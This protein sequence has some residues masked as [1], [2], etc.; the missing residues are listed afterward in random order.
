VTEAGVLGRF[1][2]TFCPSE[3]PDRLCLDT[4][5]PSR[6][7][8]LSSS[9]PSGDVTVKDQVACRYPLTKGKPG[10]KLPIGKLASRSPCFN[11]SAAERKAA[12]NQEYIL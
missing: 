9:L 4:P 1:R 8:E 3:A 10:G 7:L 11:F 2:R 12:T 6:A 5:F